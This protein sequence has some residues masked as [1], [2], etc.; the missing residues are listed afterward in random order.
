MGETTTTDACS[1]HIRA[2]S[3]GRPPR[4]SGSQPT[5]RNGLPTTISPTTAPVPEPATLRRAPDAPA[6][7]ADGEQFHAWR[8]PFLGHA[9]DRELVVASKSSPLAAS[10]SRDP[11]RAVGEIEPR[12]AAGQSRRRP[13]LGFGRHQ[14]DRKSGMPPADDACVD[15][16]TSALA[17]VAWTT[18]RSAPRLDGVELMGGLRRRRR[19]AIPAGELECRGRPRSRTSRTATARRPQCCLC[20][21]QALDE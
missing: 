5:R 19:C 3:Q 4:M 21:D 10:D 8:M 11:F 12:S 18:S 1:R 13:A 14:R 9:R 2:K 20:G 6:E 7:T 16:G 15:E 17:A